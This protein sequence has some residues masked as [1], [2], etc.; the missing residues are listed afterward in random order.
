[1]RAWGS[2]MSDNDAAR[3]FRRE[4]QVWVK[5]RS[6]RRW[7]YPS[8]PRRKKNYGDVYLMQ[9]GL[10]HLMV[11]FTSRRSEPPARGPHG[12]PQESTSSSSNS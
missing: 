8:C 5:N 10:G 4:W 12:P 7:A 3:E 6:L 2:L 9:D 1:M 11:E